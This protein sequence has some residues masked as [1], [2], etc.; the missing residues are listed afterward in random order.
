M[1]QTDKIKNR[2]D[3]K[4]LVATLAVQ[5]KSRDDE[6]MLSFIRE[7]LKSIDATVQEDGYGNIYVTKGVA[8][9][10]PC[11]IAHTDTV[12]SVLKDVSI[13]RNEDTIF[14]WDPIKRSQC[15][16]GGDDKVGVYIALQLLED[17]N[18]IKAVFFRDEEIGSLGSHY[19]MK[20]HKEWFND[21]NFVLM[22]D[23]RGNSDV[24]TV[25]GGIIITSK[26]FLETCDPLFKKYNYKD[27][28]G[29][30]TDVDVLT[31]HGIGVSCVNFSSGYWEPHSSREVVSI[32]DVNVCYN[33]MYDIIIEHG[34]TRFE[35]KAEIPA[36]KQAYKRTGHTVYSSLLADVIKTGAASPIGKRQ[37]KAFPPLIFGNSPG[38]YDLFTENEVIKGKYK[39]YMYKGI[40]SLVLTGDSICNTCKHPVVENV[41][42]LPYEGRMYC[43]QCND[44]VKDSQ[45]PL[46]LRALEVEDNDT[47]FVYSLYSSGWLPKEEAKWDTTISSWVP[48]QLPF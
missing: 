22:S 15:G 4:K 18:I 47:V 33:L 24:I 41:F 14:S 38:K 8:K 43:T 37:L 48:T 27:T 32:S 46:L 40:K 26:E 6:A 35:Y 13:Y 45:V 12:H 31:V 20:N 2:I 1:N 30:C 36:Y 16:I 19:A 25:S 21:C 11:V 3:Y 39:I 10:Y 7:K 29:I 34:N 44:Y 17:I 42:F 28:V 9:D 5:T 23:R